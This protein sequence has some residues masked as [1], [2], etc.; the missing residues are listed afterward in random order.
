LGFAPSGGTVH[1]CTSEFLFTPRTVPL[2]MRLRLYPAIGF[3]VGLLEVVATV[4]TRANLGQFTALSYTIALPQNFWTFISV[5]AVIGVRHK[6]TRFVA[7]VYV[8]FTAMDFVFAYILGYLARGRFVMPGWMSMTD[9]LCSALYAVLCL[10]V[11]FLPPTDAE[12]AERE[13]E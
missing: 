7:G 9:I 11:M 8:A 6:P 1:I 3:V 12:K 10:G 4:K 5:L 13:K 2:F